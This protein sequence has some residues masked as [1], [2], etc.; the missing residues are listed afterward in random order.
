MQCWEF[1][2]GNRVRTRETEERG[3][4]ENGRKGQEKGREGHLEDPPNS[5]MINTFVYVHLTR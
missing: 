5:S 4:K 3:V 1:Q 2:W